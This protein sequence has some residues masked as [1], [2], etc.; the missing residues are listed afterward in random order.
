[1]DKIQIKIAGQDQAFAQ[2]LG[3]PCQRA[4]YTTKP[5]RFLNQ[6][7]LHVKRIRHPEN[8]NPCTFP[9]GNERDPTHIAMRNKE[10]RT[11]PDL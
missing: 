10:S 4:K 9:R 6:V 1:M 11:D 2:N 8:R 7:R 5:T 3:C